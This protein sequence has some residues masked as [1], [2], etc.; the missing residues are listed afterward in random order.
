MLYAALSG[1]GYSAVCVSVC[2]YVAYSFG[3][4]TASGST[5]VMPR[6][7]MKYTTIISI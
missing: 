5:M 7:I 4:G 3:Q 1:F 2:V 6:I